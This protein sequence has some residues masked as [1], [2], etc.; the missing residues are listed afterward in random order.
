MVAVTALAA[1]SRRAG[2]GAGF[3]VSK[4]SDGRKLFVMAVKSSTYTSLFAAG[5]CLE[6]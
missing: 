2:D 3:V 1:A 6:L 5:A 4:A